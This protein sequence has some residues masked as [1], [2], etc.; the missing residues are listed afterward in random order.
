[1]ESEGQNGMSFIRRGR[2]FR[3]FQY[4]KQ[5]KHLIEFRR[6]T[7]RVASFRV[8]GCREAPRPLSKKPII[9]L[10]KTNFVLDKLGGAL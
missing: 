10:Q 9:A 3:L 2:A 6:C 8:I 1:M 5:E 7:R 4:S